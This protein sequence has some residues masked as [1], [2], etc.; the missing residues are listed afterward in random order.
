MKKT[1]AILL[2][3]CLFALALVG[4]TK[5]PETEN[6]SPNAMSFG[7]TESDLE[8]IVFHNVT[9][10]ITVD[11][12]ANTELK[13][14]L[15]NVTYNSL[16]KSE[17]V[18]EVLFELTIG[19]KNFNVFD[20]NEVEYNGGERVP[21][22]IDLINFMSTVIDESGARAFKD[23][24]TDVDIKAYNE[25]NA[26]VE[27]KDAEKKE[28]FLAE[29]AKIELVALNYPAHYTL[30]NH[31]YAMQIGEDIIKVYDGY[32]VVGESLYAVVGGDFD[33]LA[34]LDYPL[35]WL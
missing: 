9:F 20:G 4:C 6:N 1:V 35:P 24:G 2:T 27:V 15:R 10:G 5:K 8:S 21:V 31:L 34:D 13:N 12:S 19:G 23:Y 7:Y 11:L 18:G 14:I 17:G 16:E 28:E 26:F 25:K 29:L 3:I 22:D 32:A 33:F 30:G